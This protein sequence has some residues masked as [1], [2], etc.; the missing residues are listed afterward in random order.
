V[1]SECQISASY[2]SKLVKTYEH[3]VIQ[4]GLSHAK[5]KATDPE[6]LYLAIALKGSPERQA[7]KAE[8]LSRQEL[9]AETHEVDGKD[10]EHL[11]TIKICANC[12]AR[13]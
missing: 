5:L 13:V 11:T 4:G 7:V 10:C 8:T 12:H 2:A 9:K 6:K 1:E 3:Y